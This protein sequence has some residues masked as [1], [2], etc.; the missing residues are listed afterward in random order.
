MIIPNLMVTGMAR[1]LAFYR[2]KLGLELVTAVTADR[3]VS[4][5]ELAHDAVF[6]ILSGADGQLMLQTTRSLREELPSLAR[7]P[8]FTGTIY[9]RGLDPTSIILRLDPADIVKPL[10]RTWY[11]MFEL[12]VRD[13]DG[14]TICI[15]RTDGPPV[16]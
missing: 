15:G 9:M 14:Y 7:V 13:P 1:S 5:D 11:S 6:A 2:D 3:E 10:E 4:S 8:A 12:Y 16:T